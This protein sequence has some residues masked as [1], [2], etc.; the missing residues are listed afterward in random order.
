MS[1]VKPGRC[2][3]SSPCQQASR[4]PFRRTA[5]LRKSAGYG[6]RQGIIDPD[7]L[8]SILN[9]APKGMVQIADFFGTQYLRPNIE[10]ARARIVN[11]V[12]LFLEESSG[13]RSRPGR[14][15]A[16]R[17][18]LSFA[19][20]WRLRDAEESLGNA[21]G[22]S[23]GILVKP[24]QKE[25]LAEWSLRSL[26]EYRQACPTTRPSTGDCGRAVV[27]RALGCG[28]PPASR[29]CSVESI[30]RTAVLVYLSATTPARRTQCHRPDQHFRR[31]PEEG[32]PARGRKQLKEVFKAL[33]RSLSGG[34]PA[35]VEKGREARICR[36]YS[37]PHGR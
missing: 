25:F 13:W 29:S 28:R 19:F 26:A 15:I 12:S 36:G 34:R 20:A 33:A 16:A 22:R 8:G 10:E 9:D 1:E 4:S 17:Q 18:H 14:A 7:K 11:L 37:T 35:R 30:I 21:R 5:L 23:Y 27:C 2:E 24:S 6:V 32:N 3:T 31:H